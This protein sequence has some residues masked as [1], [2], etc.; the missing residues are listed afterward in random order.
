MGIIRGIMTILKVRDNIKQ[1]EVENVE[2]D[3]KPQTEKAGVQKSENKESP[4]ELTLLK[5]KLES[6][7]YDIEE[8]IIIAQ[9]QL[10]L[11]IAS[12]WDD[13]AKIALS[14]KHNLVDQ[15][16]KISYQVY[17]L[18]ERINSIGIDKRHLEIKMNELVNKR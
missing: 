3:L 17:K 18:D 6:E 15:K 10:E 14:M 1:A 8:K 12:K 5:N 16:M 4:V 13:L 2:K 9:E 7:L 11:S